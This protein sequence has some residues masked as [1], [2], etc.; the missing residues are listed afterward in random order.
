MSRAGR[1]KLSAVRR[2]C[3]VKDVVKNEQPSSK[4]PGRGRRD[5]R[6]FGRNRKED[7]AGG[8]I[9]LPANK[10][11]VSSPNVNVNSAPRLFVSAGLH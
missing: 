3:G 1:V 11:L 10:E 9:N 8:E 5:K 7:A 4:R 2:L 6:A